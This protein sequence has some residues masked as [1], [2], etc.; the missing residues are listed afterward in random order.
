MSK[1]TKILNEGE[2]VVKD[3]KVV[4]LIDDFPSVPTTDK[5]IDYLYIL[6]SVNSII[7]GDEGIKFPTYLK[8][9][10]TEIRPIESNVK[11]KKFSLSGIKKMIESFREELKTGKNFVKF[12]I[13]Y[14]NDD[15]LPTIRINFFQFG[16]DCG[17]KVSHESFLY[18]FLFPVYQDNFFSD[19]RIM[20]MVD[21]GIHFGFMEVLPIMN[22]CRVEFDENGNLKPLKEL[23]K[24]SENWK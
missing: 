17:N 18:P 11:N 5:D 24:Y 1:I 3:E 21:N 7:L 16:D 22:L 4:Y 20:K 6:M 9:W 10:M 2:R 19:E 8:K 15:E 14:I 23:E 12:Q 13:V